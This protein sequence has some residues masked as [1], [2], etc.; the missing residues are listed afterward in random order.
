MMA[1]A[2]KPLSSTDTSLSAKRVRHQT[3]I[4]N[5]IVVDGV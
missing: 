1:A 2:T 5:M 4:T 3:A